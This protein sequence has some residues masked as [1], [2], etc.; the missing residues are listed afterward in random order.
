MVKKIR[1]NNPS[2]KIIAGGP[3][4]WT[5][6]PEYI[7]NKIKDIDVVICNEGEFTFCELISSLIKQKPY[8]E[9][10]GI[11][12]REKNS[13]QKTSSRGLLQSDQITQP[14][15]SI[16]NRTFFPK[17]LPIQTARGCV[18]DC[19]FCS[20]V[21]FWGKPV[22]FRSNEA[23]FK[24]IEQNIN[25]F[26][27]STFRFVDSCFT[28][29]EERCVKLCDGFIERFIKNGIPIKWSSYARI[30]TL[31]PKLIEKI[32]EAGCVAVDIG[33]E[34]GNSKILQNMKKNYSKKDILAAIENLR[35]EQIISHCNVVVGFPGETVETVSETTDILNVAQPDTYHCMQ[36]FVAN[37]THLSNNRQLYLL[38]GHQLH[39]QHPTMSNET[40]A[41]SIKKITQQIKSSCLFIAGEYISILLSAK[42]FSIEQIKSLFS[43]LKEGILPNQYAEM[44]KCLSYRGDFPNH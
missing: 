39:W 31:T 9:I 18:Y 21:G 38:E 43:N 7:L 33:M 41:T 26:G 10:Q 15:W 14:D 17:L 29:P 1:S 36:L 30:N 25:M 12:Y 11:Y 42:G 6:S 44:I 24:E 2:C 22:R 32:K 3:L 28:A 16:I 34:S 40:A 13:I 8:T 37:N 27:T 23:V 5:F 20:E 19:S 35:K 4:H